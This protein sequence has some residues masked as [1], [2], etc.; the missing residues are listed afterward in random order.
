MDA[1]RLA[2]VFPAASFEAERLPEFQWLLVEEDVPLERPPEARAV[3]VLFTDMRQDF[4]RIESHKGRFPQG[5]EDALF[6]LLLAPWEEWSR[7]PE[8]DWRGFRLPWV[9]TTDKDLFVRPKAPPSPESLSWEPQALT[10]AWGEVVEIER[11]AALPL[12]EQAGAFLPNWNQAA[13]EA[14]CRARESP[15]FE[16]PVAHF[17]ARAYLQDGVDES[18]ATQLRL[19]RRSGSKLIMTESFGRNRTRDSVQRNAL[20]PGSRLSLGRAA[21]QTTT[22]NCFASA[23]RFFT[24]CRWVRSR[25]PSA[26]SRASSLVRSL[27]PSS[28]KQSRALPGAGRIIW[29]LCLIADCGSHEHWLTA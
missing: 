15:L 4:G 9:Y 2:R 20:R 1:A 17:F 8:V 24:E 29:P 7:M 10:E 23:A 3:P 16:T 11:P 21:R 6:F 28:T 13:W 12:E 25:L 18:S 19:R 22:S 5:V 14:V 26:F 27:P